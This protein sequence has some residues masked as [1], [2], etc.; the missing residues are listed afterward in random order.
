M[1]VWYFDIWC[2]DAKNLWHWNFEFCYSQ[3]KFI[4]YFTFLWWIWIMTS[5]INQCN[6]QPYANATSFRN[7]FFLLR[8]LAIRRAESIIVLRFVLILTQKK[9]SLW[10][11]LQN[12]HQLSRSARIFS[13]L[14]DFF[15][16][17]ANSF[18]CQKQSWSCIEH[19]VDDINNNITLYRTKQN[20]SVV[21]F[22]ELWVVAVNKH[23]SAI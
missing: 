13:L 14:S 23:N 15:I 12:A 11:I 21:I 5:V 2:W 10:K 17:I 19:W 8:V 16:S 22:S 4:V 7:C 3:S 6:K 20:K 18:G 9:L 1:L